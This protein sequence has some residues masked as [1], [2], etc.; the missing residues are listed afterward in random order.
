MGGRAF[1]ALTTVTLVVNALI[2]LVGFGSSPAISVTAFWRTITVTGLDRSTVIIHERETIAYEAESRPV[3]NVVFI[4][5]ESV[6]GDH[7][8]LNGYHRVT[9]PYLEVMAAQGL[10]ANWGIASSAAACSI[11]SNQA[12]MMG[13]SALPDPENQI[14]TNATIFQYAKAMGYE[15]HY[16]DAQVNHLWN[17]MT[18]ADLTAVDHWIRRR[19]LSR[20]NDVDFLAADYIANVTR[21]SVGHF[22]VVNKYGV[23]FN[24]NSI[25]PPEATV[26]TPVTTGKQYDDPVEVINTYDNA[27]LYNVD[28]FFRR[29]LPDLND[30]NQTV[31]LY[32]SDHG[33]TLLQ[34]GETWLHCGNTRNE[35]IVPLLLISPEPYDVDPEY[36]ASHFNI[37]ATLLDLMGV[38][39]TMRLRDYPLS[40]LRATSAD[41]TDRYFLGGVINV[42]GQ[43]LE[44]LLVISDAILVNFDA[45]E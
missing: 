34:D 35:A 22:I 44:L 3:N 7:L 23:H 10:I 33:Q 31:F 15:T 26:W 21:D 12:M 11:Q 4:I 19:D 13:L 45:E 18:A 2:Y 6:R 43:A 42:R 29:L 25:Y 14:H 5:D 9:T 40:L 27:I 36:R 41:S 38:P 20:D 24:Y 17:G 37:F 28:T 16:L 39:E 1:L 8:S 30:L 32:T